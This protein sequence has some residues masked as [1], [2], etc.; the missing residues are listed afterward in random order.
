MFYRL[1]VLPIVI[2]LER[3]LRCIWIW[4]LLGSVQGTSSALGQL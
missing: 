3:N 2:E 1:D 4:P